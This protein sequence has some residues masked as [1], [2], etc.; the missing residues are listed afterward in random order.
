MLFLCLCSA[1]VVT[2]AQLVQNQ[3]SVTRKAGE[4]VSI[5]CTGF[6]QCDNSFVYWYQKK[7]TFTVLLRF[8]RSGQKPTSRFSHPQKMDFSAMRSES[9]CEL[10][11]SSSNTLHAATYY[12]TCQKVVH[13]SEN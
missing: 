4:T 10:V 1:L 2:A 8:D 6:D 11:I 12:C 13:H 5:G 3:L 9:G 7:E